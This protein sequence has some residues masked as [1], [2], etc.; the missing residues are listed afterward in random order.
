VASILQ[1]GYVKAHSLFLT[2]YLE[3]RV[4]FLLTYYADTKCSDTLLVV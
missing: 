2:M 3:E 4:M 1:G